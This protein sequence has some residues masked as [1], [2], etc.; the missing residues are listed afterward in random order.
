MEKKNS[1]DEEDKICEE[2][3]ACLSVSGGCTA[4][5][6]SVTGTEKHQDTS[7]PDSDGGDMQIE[8]SREDTCFVCP[9]I[10][11]DQFTDPEE[12]SNCEK[13]RL[14]MEATKGVDERTT[15]KQVELDIFE[16]YE[17]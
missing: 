3:S 1:T 6:I 13:K 2:A 12:A 7:I 15:N 5:K 8:S 17:Y 10:T 9:D 4:I 11:V 16:R 14:D